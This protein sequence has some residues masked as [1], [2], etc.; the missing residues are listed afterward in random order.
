MPESMLSGI[1]RHNRKGERV[2]H[3]QRTKAKMRVA[4]EVGYYYP[5]EHILPH[6]IKLYRVG[7]SGGSSR[8]GRFSCH[9][10]DGRGYN[11]VD[12]GVVYEG[13]DCP[14]CGGGMY[15]DKLYTERAWRRYRVFKT[16][17]ARARM[18]IYAYKWLGHRDKSLA[19]RSGDKTKY[20]VPK[21][22][23]A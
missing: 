19:F 22:H 12:N 18:D 2:N 23:A 20:F 1:Q 6:G 7:S 11:L 5:R 8:Q 17:A 4:N 14:Y 13:V 10:C 9:K 16:K 3:V 15:L 21:W